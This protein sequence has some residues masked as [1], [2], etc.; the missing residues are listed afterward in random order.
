V[1]VWFKAKQ[2]IP[3]E[4]LVNVRYFIWNCRHLI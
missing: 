1:A 3:V 4:I 2:G